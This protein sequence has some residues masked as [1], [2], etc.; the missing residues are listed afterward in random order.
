MTISEDQLKLVIVQFEEDRNQL[1]KELNESLLQEDYISAHHFSEA[2]ERL[3]RQLNVLYNIHDPFYDEKERFKRK[4]E[5]YQNRIANESSEW[6]KRAFEKELNHSIEELNN[7]NHVPKQISSA[8]KSRILEN[9]LMN[10]LDRKIKNL[11]LYLKRSENLLMDFTFSKK[12]LK[13]TLPNVKQ[14]SKKWVLQDIHI[15]AIKNVGFQ[16]TKDGS[17]LIMNITGNQDK[18]LENVNQILLKI[19]FEIFHFKEFENDCFLV[20][21]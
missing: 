13:V 3:N 8:E 17:K 10:L 20:I 1:Q 4:I 15:L 2:I 11:K 7:L 21:G 16:P 5:I 14:L 18:I 12:T 19:I 9:T 6:A